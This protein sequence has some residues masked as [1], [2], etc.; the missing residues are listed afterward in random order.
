MA[1]GAGV[2]AAAVQGRGDRRKVR[3]QSAR[4]DR[5]LAALAASRPQRVGRPGRGVRPRKLQPRGGGRAPD[6]RLEAVRQ[7]PA[8]LHRPRLCDA[9]GGACDRHDP[10]ALQADRPPA[11]PDAA[12]GNADHQA[13]RL[14]DQGAPARA[15]VRRAHG[16]GRSGAR[17]AQRRRAGRRPR[18]RSFRCMGCRCWSCSARTWGPRKTQRAASP[19]WRRRKASA[20]A[21][22]GSTTSSASCRSRAAC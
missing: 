12:E 17:A 4:A 10:A 1:D 20:C 3:A 21:S 7:R 18:P 16:A 9:R 13:G 6:Q 15:R 22:P 11:L 14:Q 5:A 2:R 8:R 19:T